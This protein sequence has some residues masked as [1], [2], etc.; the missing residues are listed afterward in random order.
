[1]SSTPV[2]VSGFKPTSCITID[3]TKADPTCL[4]ALEAMLYGDTSSEP[5]L[6]LPD[7]VKTTMTPA[8]G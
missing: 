4:A 6:P 8:G 1:M 5:T 7:V 3:S 2:S